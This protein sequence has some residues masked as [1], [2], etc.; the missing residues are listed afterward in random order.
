LSRTFERAILARWSFGI[1]GEIPMKGLLFAAILTIALPTAALAAPQIKQPQCSA[2][3]TW[4]ARVN[5]ELVNVAP[6]VQ[7]PK[8]LGD[9]EVVPLFG[10]SVLDWTQEDLQAANQVL[11]KCWND[12]RAHRDGAAANAFVNGNRALQG[13]VP[14]V[15]GI[16]RKAKAD[17]APLEQAIAKLPDSPDLDR[18]LEAV[19]KLDLARPDFAP[20]RTLPREIADPVSRLAAQ[21]LPVLANGDR[22]KLFQSLGAR[23]AGMQAA[24]TSAAAKSIAAAPENADGLIALIAVRRQVSA[25]DDAGARTR[26]L[27]SADEKAQKIRGALRQAKPAQWVPPDCVD[28]YRWSS[29]P[30]AGTGVNVGDRG[31]IQT[32]F[33]D[34][35]V[36]P[37]FGVSL[38]TWSDQ[39]FA[40]FKALRTACSAEWEA[41]AAI[42]ANA[43][44]NAPE[45]VQLGRR[46]RWIDGADRAVGDARNL[47]AAYGKGQQALAAAIAKVQALPDDAAS[48]ASLRQLMADP[49]LNALSGADRTAYVNAVNAKAAVIG[50]R[51]AN[52]AL[53]GLAEIKVSSAADVDKIWVYG[54]NAIQ[55][56]PDARSR[57][58]VVNAVTRKLQ[59]AAQQLETQAKASS[60]AKPATLASVAEANIK[61]LKLRSVPFGVANTPAF[62]A[63]FGA[64]QAGR[65]ALA[66]SARTKACTEFDASVGAGGDAKQDLWDGRE[67]MPLG[68]FLCEAAEHGTVNSY[69][70]PGMFSS[71]STIKV[72]PVNSQMF[73]VSLHKVEVQAGHPMLVGYEVKDAAQ[74][75][76]KQPAPTGKPGYSLTPNGPI[77]V[78][79]WEMFIPTIIGYGGVEDQ[80]CMKLL[81][82]PAPDKLAPAA[83]VFYLHCWTY[84]SVRDHLASQGMAQ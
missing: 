34:Q 9:A 16:L 31:A 7:L 15:N 51:V 83:K 2:L 21:V 70:G 18:G 28:L 10:V 43:G 60:D 37:V 46:G 52:T 48:L 80:T 73:T 63:Y 81:R 66:K 59:E 42:P 82:D 47:L 12:A 57:E 4:G 33:T 78:E 27:K 11:T 79:G 26:L 49:S 62:H 54:V 3:E 75:Q 23:H 55:A 69:S 39:D 35:R 76:A 84:Q 64:L 77:T 22:E 38:G 44:P 67:A 41:E 40:R 6:R 36:I 56:I 45:L 14:R 24:M 58:T 29:A 5:G 1:Q 19:L 72:T 65:D 61:L 50:A 8:A 68:E 32:A 25:L 53:K 71:T 13:W 17:A 20:F 74:A 30:D